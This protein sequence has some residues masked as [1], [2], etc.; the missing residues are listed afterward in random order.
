VAPSSKDVCGS[1]HESAGRAAVE[2]RT[3][4][5]HGRE[6]QILT[7]EVT[8]EF[9]AGVSLDK[10]KPPKEMRG[11]KVPTSGGP[12]DKPALGKEDLRLQLF[13][14]SRS[15]KP[16]SPSLL[17]IPSPRLKFTGDQISIRA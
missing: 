10:R 9:V 13:L 11:I 5:S 3:D 12:P 15:C 7:E 16:R 4:S 8:L 6:S 2:N 14:G 1:R 17:L